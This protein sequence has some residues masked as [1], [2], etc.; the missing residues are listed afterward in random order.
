MGSG[1]SGGGASLAYFA[2]NR[3]QLIGNSAWDGFFDAISKPF[4][5]DV[6]DRASEWRMVSGDRLG[7][8]LQES[9]HR[10]WNLPPD[11]D[12]LGKIDDFGLIFNTTLAGHYKD[13]GAG[14]GTLAERASQHPRQHHSNLAGGRLIL[15]NLSIKRAF[16][17]SNLPY[18]QQT[19][20][21]VVIDD[22]EMP[23]VTAA[24]LNANFPPVFSNAPVDVDQR[25]RYWVTDGGAADNR[26]LEMLMYALRDTLAAN[27]SALPYGA[28]ILVVDA[29]AESDS[30][31]Q[32]RGIGSAIGAGAQFAMH[33]SAEIKRDIDR[34]RQDVKLIYLRMPRLLR[35]SGSFGTHWMLQDNIRVNDPKDPA[36]D[37]C[38]L[39]ALQ[40][41][42]A[43]KSVTGTEAITMLR[44]LYGGQSTGGLSPKSSEVLEWLRQS[45]E[46]TRDWKSVADWLAATK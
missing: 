16:E 10:H 45:E 36:C 1:V 29:G 5:Q 22:P 14:P 30:F 4:I 3:R 6:L 9:F 33:L 24:A 32:D 8:L 25:T 19:P 12:K 15:T 44:A 17:G 28:L 7:T 39:A 42:W 2:S 43:A 31:S 20:L 40:E 26:G 18:Y 11:R 23:L 35:A 27:P 13:D 37:S 34:G 21:P 41:W 46:Y 38:P